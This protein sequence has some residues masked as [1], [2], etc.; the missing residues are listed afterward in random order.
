MEALIILG[1]LAVIVLW[2]FV[3]AEFRRIAAMKGHN[4]ARYF[5]W[6][7]LFSLVG[8]LMVIALPQA[9]KASDVVEPD[10]LPEI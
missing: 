4:E 1:A 6:T 8:M 3:A 7:F 2:Y 10:E 9:T 5:W